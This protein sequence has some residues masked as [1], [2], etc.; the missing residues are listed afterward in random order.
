M[1]LCVLD[2]PAVPRMCTSGQFA[3]PTK[4]LLADRKTRPKGNKAKQFTN[5]AGAKLFGRG[6]GGV[7]VVPKVSFGGGR[8][9]PGFS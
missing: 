4:K 5:W 8:R 1:S 3:A 7:G 9:G 2:P 6:E